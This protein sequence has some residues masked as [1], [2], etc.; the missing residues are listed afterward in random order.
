M[1]KILIV[2]IIFA[3][4]SCGQQKL[5]PPQMTISPQ[6][7]IITISAISP[8]TFDV[9]IFS[10]EDLKRFEIKTEPFIFKVDTNFSGFIH[11]MR[12]K[13]TVEIPDTIVGLGADSLIKVT[14]IA[15][16]AYNSEEQYRFLKIESGYPK[17][18]S[19]SETLYFEFD[20]AMFYSAIDTVR[21]SFNEIAHNFD[22][23]ML[24]D[25]NDGF[26]LAS[27]DAFYV[28]LKMS[29]LGYNYDDTEQRTTKFLKFSTDFEQITPKF[30][31]NLNIKDS[32][33]D[34]NAGYGYGIASL[35]KNNT[36]AFETD[37]GKKG[38]L[39][40]DSLNADKK[41]MQFRVKVQE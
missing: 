2:L 27:P 7:S 37:E 26:V 22:I 1:K 14:F 29:S 4:G 9:N 39:I 13:K 40:I 17:L 24:Y 41:M 6:D 33:I 16:D 18:I 19:D 20:S 5:E 32:Y 23:V 10:N 12:Y 31:Y 21:L 11:K 3:L 15:S 36:V 30:V 34:E 38:V 25:Q 28:K 8:V 35:Q